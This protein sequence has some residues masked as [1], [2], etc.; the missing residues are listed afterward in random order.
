MNR[1]VTV[2]LA[3]VGRM[4]LTV[5]ASAAVIVGLWY[6]FIAVFDLNSLV[7]KDPQAVWDYLFTAR[8]APASRKAIMDGLW[9]TLGDAG[10]GY[11]FGT[12][13]AIVVAVTFVLFRPVERAL[14][15]VAMML[16]SVPL[17]AMI[18]LLTL[19]FGRGLV[20]VGVIA[21]IIVFFPSL[22]NLV[23]GLRSG[24]PA[25]ADLVHAYGGGPVMVLRKVSL[26]SALP[27]LFVSARIAVPGAII[28]ALLAEWLATGQGLGYYMQRAQQTFN[29][30]GVWASVVVITV[31]SI[32]LY[33]VVGFLEAVVLAR[34]GPSPGRGGRARR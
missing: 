14:M 11:L 4:M 28:G 10:L 20:A 32:V 15:P 23:F 29:Y 3:R 5:L 31:A 22:V 9:H 17:V 27:A 30:G 13:A 1:L 21:G 24:P 26:P 33:A 25:A 12:V 8:R 7:A 16:R 19:V 2:V 6:A 18:P 34:Y